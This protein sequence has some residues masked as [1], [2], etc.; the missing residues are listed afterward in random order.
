MTLASPTLSTDIVTDVSLLEPTAKVVAIVPVYNEEEIV[1]RTITSLMN[2]TYQLDTVLVVA[3]N[4]SDNTVPI[5]QSLQAQYGLDR[6]VLLEMPNNPHK[7]A[8]ALNY[9]IEVLT[10]LYGTSAPPFVFTMDGDTVLHERIIEMGVK[11]LKREP[12]TGG[13]CAAYRTLPLQ[14]DATKWQ[15]FLWRLQNIEF[16][17]AN[18][19]RIEH[20]NS[21]RVLPGVST[22]FR[23]DA[24][25]DIEAYNRSRGYDPGTI[26]VPNHQVEDYV[27]TLDLKDIGWDVKSSHHMISWSDVPLHL[28]GKA[29]LWDQRQRWYSGTVDVLRERKLAKHSRYDLFTISLLVMYLAMRLLFMTGMIILL[30][31]VHSI[32]I[33]P[34]FLALP[35]LAIAL[36]LHRLLKFGDQ[37]DKWQIFFTA[38]LVVNEAYAIYR[39][40]LYTYSIWLSYRRPNRSW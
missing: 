13:V 6:L 25:K 12:N 17:L 14:E 11:K 29:G 15:R 10:T 19:W 39:E 40:M 23:L 30:A 5:V 37:L 26:W 16:G 33:V 31:T 20:Y 3:N 34:I 28:N 18:A 7:K 8:G 24:L 35:A 32:E 38:T 9:G 1:E 2:Q 36:Q 4:C 22:M 27:L 21:A